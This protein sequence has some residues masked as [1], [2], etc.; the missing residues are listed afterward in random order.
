MNTYPLWKYLML[1]AALALSVVYGLPNIYGDD[2][3]LQIV[4]TRSAQLTPDVTKKLT[5][6]LTQASLGFQAPETSGQGLLIRFANTEQQLKAQELAKATLGDDF[7]VALNL[8]PATPNWLRSLGAGPMKL[9]LDLRGGVH[10]LMQ[11]DMEEATNKLLNNYVDD[12]KSTL[13]EKRL[14]YSSVSL[15]KNNLLQASFRQADFRDEA[16]TVLKRQFREL[17]FVTEDRDGQFVLSATITEQKIKEMRDYAVQQNLTTLSKRI[18]SIGVAEPLIQR[19][20]A[21]RIV[22]ELPGVQDASQAKKVLGTTASLE[23]RLVD[24]KNDVRD[25]LE[26]RIPSDSILAKSRSGQPMLLQKQL[27]LTGDH[28]TDATTGTDENGRPQVSIV[29]D[30]AGGD[31]FSQGTKE[32]VGKPMATLF[33]EYKTETKMVDGKEVT[34]HVKVEEI[35]NVATIRSQLSTRFQITGID[36]PQEAQDLALALR[37]GALIAPIH[38]IEERTIGPSLGQENIDMGIK[39]CVYSFGLVV[40]FMLMFYRVFGLFANT[41]LLVNVLMLVGVMSLG[42]FTLTLPGIAGIVLTMGMAVDAN[43]LICERI[44]EE[45]RN[46]ASP[47]MAIHAG[48]DR[49]FATIADSNLT[50]FIAG[51]VLFAVGTGPIKGFAITL[52]IG[53][54]TSMFTAVTGTRALVNLVYGSRQLTSLKV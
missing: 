3:A 4:G 42:G 11:V 6:A 50:T 35:I 44:K 38:I 27:M 31:K 24:E 15:S 48:Y 28:I 25:A 33:I 10:F 39:A 19:Q 12:F 7:I 17:V 14:R 43:V 46:G 34:H 1:V 20:G 9:G 30:G 23:F 51:V 52:C 36:T 32:A 5:D 13:R 41:A 47:A 37:A 49:A 2:P 29:L 40:I 45:L 16:L 21:D 18:N 54:V 8:A 22:V 26:G 53:L